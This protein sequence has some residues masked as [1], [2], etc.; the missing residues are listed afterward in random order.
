MARNSEKAM[1]ALARWRNAKLAEE[2]APAKDDRRP[3]LATNCDNLKDA[4]KWRLQIIREI[5]RKVSQIQNAGLGE[6]KIRDLNDEINKL[7][8]E[9]RHWENRIVE[10]GGRDMKRRSRMLDKEGK[11]IP[12]SHGYK[13][14]GAARELPGV[15]ELFEAQDAPPPK[16]TRAELMKDI[17]AH[18]YGFRDDDDGLLVPLELEAERKA[19]DAAVKEWK[20]KKAAAPGT[21]AAAGNEENDD[22]VDIYRA[23]APPDVS[24]EDRMEEAMK[25]GKEARFVS[26]VPIPSQKD[27][28][29][30]LLRRKKLEL[31]KEFALDDD[32]GD[33]DAQKEEKKSVQAS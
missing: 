23:L 3:Y 8:R 31:L 15:K 11:E 24:E 29:D 26:H 17:D 1:T 10:L 28:Q 9:K 7:L 20:E 30:A 4:E 22:D 14:F 12:G 18:Y 25:A 5:S 32:D 21:A 19:I 6:F 2:G 16:K 27:I 13:Y 33:D